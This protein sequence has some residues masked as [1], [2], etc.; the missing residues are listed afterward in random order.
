VII[1]GIVGNS[2]DASVAVFEEGPFKDLKCR[3][4]GLSKDFSGIEHDPHLNY[5]MLQ[6]I[7]ITEGLP[8]PD[9][10]VWYEKPWLKSLRQL[11]AGQGWLFGENNIKRY[12]SKWNLYQPI[13]YVRHHRAHAAYGYYTSG[14][15]NATIICLD[16]IGEY[17]TF[18]VWMG[19][20][21][22]LKQIYSQSYPHSVGLFYSAMTQ[23]LGLQANRDEYLVEPMGRDIST[24]ENLQLVNDMIETFIQD[25]LDGSVPGVKFKHNLH[26]GANWYKPEL[27]TKNDMSRLANATQFVFELMLKSTSKWC[28]QNLPSHNL[29]LTGGCALN[30]VAVDGIE[31][32]WNYIYVP[33]NPGDPGS[34]IG[35]VL[36][37]KNK[38]I[39]FDEKIWYNKV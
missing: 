16:S 36:A 35:A 38:H 17:E 8:R 9:K 31:K 2:H 29:I 23:R 25:P 1:W 19:E 26:K 30:K 27:Y 4:A 13:K 20:G 22:K 10:I 11:Q 37:L 6:H 21:N 3:W 14:L 32:K 33:K 18:T 24:Q 5:D 12:L 28:L 15:E 34:C 39:D 7:T